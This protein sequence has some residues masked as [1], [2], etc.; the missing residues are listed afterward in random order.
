MQYSCYNKYAKQSSPIPKSSKS[1][2]WKDIN[3]KKTELR[4]SILQSKMYAAKRNYHI[5][6][7]M[8]LKKLTLI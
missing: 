1:F 5:R 4:L 3:W 8:E 2:A 6:K 7:V